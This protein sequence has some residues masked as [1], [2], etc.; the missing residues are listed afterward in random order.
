MT[1]EEKKQN[2]LLVSDNK[3]HHK[4]RTRGL[5]LEKHDLFDVKKV[6]THNLPKS[7]KSLLGNSLTRLDSVLE[8][9]DTPAFQDSLLSCSDFVPPQSVS[10]FGILQSPLVV[11]KAEDGWSPRE[12]SVFESSL[13]IHGKDFRMISELIKTKS[14]KEVI[15]FYYIWKKTENYSRWK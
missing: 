1:G 2:L 6:Q 5:S 11:S 14:T 8:S 4:N 13:M 7:V 15:E 12:V 10:S 9:P 3:K